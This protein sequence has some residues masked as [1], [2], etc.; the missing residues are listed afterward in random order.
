MTDAGDAALEVR[1]R[2][3]EVKGIT[4]L[5]WDRNEDR[6]GLRTILLVLVILLLAGEWLTRKLVRM[7]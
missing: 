7:V 4:A 5:V 6:F 3:N 1:E 2:E